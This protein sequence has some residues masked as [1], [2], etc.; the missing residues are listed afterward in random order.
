L[1]CVPVKML[2]R[3]VSM[4]VMVWVVIGL[5]VAAQKD[6]LDHLGSLSGLLSAILAVIVWPLVLLKVHFG[7]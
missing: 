7:V 3:Q 5:I 6:F 1:A 4:G 2:R